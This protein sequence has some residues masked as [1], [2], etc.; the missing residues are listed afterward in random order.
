MDTT[1]APDLIRLDQIG[2]SL[3]LRPIDRSW[4]GVLARCL[5][6]TPPILISDTG[7]LIDGA[8]R[9]E[10]ARQLGRTTIRVQQVAGTAAELLTAGIAANVAHGQ[11]LTLPQ[12]RTAARRLLEA[13]PTRSDRSVAHVC[14]LSP[15][16]IGRIRATAGVHNGQFRVGQD[17]RCYPVRPL[18]AATTKADAPEP[19]L[20]RHRVLARRL[21]TLVTTA[22][23][24]A[25]RWRRRLGHAL[26]P[27]RPTRT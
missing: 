20:R 11:P 5:D 1:D 12:R 22:A 2:P 19:Q 8:H 10:A 6:A 13:D 7:V 14:G 27:R 18:A 21:A 16:T 3:D 4:V 15:T 26:R 9:V 17:G 25:R 23:A 24:T